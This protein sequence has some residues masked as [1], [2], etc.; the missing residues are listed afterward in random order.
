V[1][2]IVAG[3]PA[4]LAVT[5]A[6][7]ARDMQR[8][9]VGYGRGGR[10]RIESD[11]VEIAGGI[12]HGLTL[13]S[14]VC[15]VVANGDW[16]NWR[17][18]MSAEEPAPGWRSERRVTV[19][20]PGHADL[21][22]GAKFG[23]ADMR[24][25][26]ERASARETVGRV[27]GGA[28]CRLLLAE[29]GVSIVSRTISIGGI[30]AES[31]PPGEE[32]W[33]AVEASDLRCADEAAGELMHARIDEA[34]AA[35]DS[36]G[37]V[38][39]VVVLGAPPGLGSYVAWD[40]RLDG[41][42]AQALMSVPAIKGVE[43]GAGFAAAELPGSEVH[44]PIEWDGSGGWAFVRPSNNAGGI[45]GGVTNGEAI[46]ARLAMKPI[47]TL[48]KPLASVDTSSGEAVEAHAERSDV[49]AVPAAGVVGEA[50]A[51][52]TLASEALEKFG[53]DTVDDMKAAREAYM[54]RLGLPWS[55][56]R[57]DGSEA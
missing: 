19:P 3:I 49:C 17:E 23:H 35:G 37:G 32:D 46:V 24:N 1:T 36:V 43:I 16:A 45:E 50:M 15:L 20:R 51:A 48:T 54:S 8:R 9:Q 2:A 21:S 40:E 29:I 28:L 18:E 38:V 31:R 34:K 33:D 13:G 41:R 53:G 42:L 12:R 25:V 11:R 7:I 56:G 30:V 22:G 26:L 4:G 10:M 27:A 47:P 44:D 5:A 14:P 52:L 57:P 55:G 6:A 39:E